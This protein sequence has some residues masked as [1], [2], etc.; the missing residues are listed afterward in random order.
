MTPDNKNILILISPV[1]CVGILYVLAGEN[2]PLYRLD[3]ADMYVDKLHVGSNFLRDPSGYSWA[4]DILRGWPALYGSVTPHHIGSVLSLIVPPHIAF[5][6]FILLQEVLVIFGAYW[7]ARQLV[8]LDSRAAFFCA[9]VYYAQFVFFK[10]NIYVTGVSLLPA[11]IVAANF[12]HERKQLLFIPFVFCLLYSFLYPPYTLPNMAIYHLI[13]LLIVCYSLNKKIAPYILQYFVFWVGYVLFYWPSLW[14]FK[15]E[16]GA[17]NRAAWEPTGIDI[18]FSEG[19]SE[20]A[21]NILIFLSHSGV[22]YPTI[23]LLVVYAYSAHKTRDTTRILRWT[24]F[25]CL[26]IVL[27][28]ALIQSKLFHVILSHANYLTSLSFVYARLFYIIPLVLFVGVCFL[29][30]T[31]LPKVSWNVCAIIILVV[32]VAHFLLARKLLW[33]MSF[34]ILSSI[35]ILFYELFL[36]GRDK[37]I[38][39]LIGWSFLLI[40][41]YK[42]TEILRSQMPYGLL[43][44]DKY[45]SY[46]NNIKPYRILSIVTT[47]SPEEFYPAQ[48]TIQGLQSIDGVSV[49]YSKQM[50]EQWKEVV[51]KG[52]GGCSKEFSHWTNRVELTIDDWQR[53]QHRIIAWAKLNNVRFI[54]SRVRLNAPSLE[55]AGESNI[56][57]NNWVGSM[58]EF[59]RSGASKEHEAIYP[60]YVYEIA[61][62][63]RIF[64]VNPAV[65]Q[66]L[67]SDDYIEA[68]KRPIGRIKSIPLRQSVP[69]ILN[70]TARGGREERLLISENYHSDWH[71]KVDDNDVS[72]DNLLTKGPMGILEI[73]PLEG[74]HRYHLY[75]ANHAGIRFYGWI[76]LSF[77]WIVA[78][79]AYSKR[80]GL[81]SISTE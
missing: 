81:S 33:S 71:L 78:M 24:I 79:V 72:M 6:L 57:Q 9:L 63:G 69:S 50:A 8:N 14:G 54:R 3:V 2:A 27:V 30:R 26:I 74:L 58:K 73:K 62:Y 23:V 56:R 43:L 44:S 36:N 19:L 80:K 70:F 47:C 32:T 46:V 39:Y 5:L 61:D 38:I 11:V 20:I 68:I 12:K 4:A 37:R 16:W 42:A 76:L 66:L 35:L 53:N 40:G 1:I 34:F 55:F 7:F 17:S 67:V 25:P 65:H 52:V 28:T 21:R 13:L 45:S 18:G 48:A 15:S 10:E 22:L 64:S 75:F 49:F 77:I 59:L 31:G 60:F 51:K 29:I 41:P